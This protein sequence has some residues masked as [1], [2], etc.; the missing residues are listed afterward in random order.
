VYS[1]TLFETWALEEDRWSVP[2]LGRLT[3]IKDPVPIAERARW[4]LPL[5]AGMENLD[6]TGIRSSDVQPIASRYNGYIF[7]TS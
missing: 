2:R 5:W 7:P 4:A 1:S 3:P 6:P